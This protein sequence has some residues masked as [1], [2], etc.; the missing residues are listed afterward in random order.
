MSLEPV[1]IVIES[2]S[3]LQLP[4]ITYD[5]NKNTLKLGT[6]LH[7]PFWNDSHGFPTRIQ[8]KD[9]LPEPPNFMKP[10]NFTGKDSL[11]SIKLVGVYA[12]YESAQSA[13]LCIPNRKL[14]GPAIIQ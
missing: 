10:N 6:N 2:S 12:N 5:H 3:S 1:W 4:I 7:Q 8:D 13:V 9:Y 14:L 11:G